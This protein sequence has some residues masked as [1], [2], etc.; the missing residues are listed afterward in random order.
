MVIENL[1]QLEKLSTREKWVLVDELW[2]ALLAEAPAC[3]ADPAI[4][5]EL[6]RR[7]VEYE[8]N[9]GSG[10]PWERVRDRMVDRA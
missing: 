9:P 5:A 7:M 2:S 1:P 10:M 8:A 6:E 4:V 3:E